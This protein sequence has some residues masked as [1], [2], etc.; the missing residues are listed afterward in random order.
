MKKGNR[1]FTIIELIVVMTIIMM[2]A[3]LVAAAAQTARQRAL[4]ARTRAMIAGI[5]TGL[6]MFQSD[7]GGYPNQGNT[8]L[9]TCLMSN[10][11]VYFVGANQNLPNANWAGPYMTFK[12]N[13]LTGGNRII[14]AWGTE[15]IY[16]RPD[17]THGGSY[18]DIRSAGP[19]KTVGNADDITNWTR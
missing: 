15:Y 3:G 5:E 1:G 12:D 17:T 13:D 14:D 7:L 9:F 10:T 11:G 4:I 19:D 6:G 18:V 16:S 8:N 2:L